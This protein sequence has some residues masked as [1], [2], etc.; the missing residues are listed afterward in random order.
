MPTVLTEAARTAREL[1]DR[2][3]A[4]KREIDAMLAAGVGPR[5]GDLILETACGTAGTGLMIGPLVAP[6]GVVICS[7]SAREML[8]A[9]RAVAEDRGVRNVDFRCLDA[10]RLDLRDR[11]VDGVVCRLGLMVLRKPAAALAEARRVLRFGGR[12]AVAV[13]SERERNP[14]RSVP[15]EVLSIASDPTRPGPFALADASR[16]TT[17]LAAAGFDDIRLDRVRA[18]HAYASPDEFWSTCLRKSQ[19]VRKAFGQLH[20]G[21]R[22]AAKEEILTRLAGCAVGAH[23][24]VLPAEM[25]VAAGTAP[26]PASITRWGPGL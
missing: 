20:A 1:A 18:D 2:L 17:L 11:C 12:I 25:L 8:E 14:W 13:W 9:A 16:L 23:G 7:D 21:R 19:T 15:E 26:A 5:P 3:D 22:S 10:E 6:G 24:F 4:E